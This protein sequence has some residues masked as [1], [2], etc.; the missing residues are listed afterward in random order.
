M[1]MFFEFMVKFLGMIEAMFIFFFTPM[2]D[3]ASMLLARFSEFNSSF[4]QRML[5]FVS[6]V[7]LPLIGS[8]SIAELLLGGGI[9]VFL[10]HKFILFIWP[11]GD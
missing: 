10:L 4:V 8:F 2:S 7:S 6:S 3:V 9:L 11:F 1:E 5:S